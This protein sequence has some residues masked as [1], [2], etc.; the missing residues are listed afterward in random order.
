M[1][2]VFIITLHIKAHLFVGTIQCGTMNW[3]NIEQN[4]IHFDCCRTKCANEFV[5]CRQTLFFISR[6]SHSSLFPSRAFCRGNNKLTPSFCLHF[7][8]PA[9]PIMNNASRVPLFLNGCL[10]LNLVCRPFRGH[11]PTGPLAFRP[12]TLCSDLHAPYVALVV[13][14]K[15]PCYSF[16]LR[17]VKLLFKNV[18]PWTNAILF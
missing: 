11:A 6:N 18:T 12:L 14:K 4:N 15:C 7:L 9:I 5:N 1:T 8:R 3:N 13:F 17:A 16:V 2:T 10:H